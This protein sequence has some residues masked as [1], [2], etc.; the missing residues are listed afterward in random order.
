MTAASLRPALRAVETIVVPD[1]QHGRMLVLRDTEGVAPG[2]VSIPPPLIPVVA[3]FTGDKTCAQLARDLSAELGSEV[4][5]DVV[6]RA[7]KALEEALFL[8]GPA[9][10]AA[11]AKVTRWRVPRSR[12]GARRCRRRGP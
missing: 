9:Y 2:S 5:V 1:P 12:S 6:V 4:A 7:A 10:R 3:R 11:R 8:E